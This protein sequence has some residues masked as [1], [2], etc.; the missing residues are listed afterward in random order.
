[1]ASPFH[2][3]NSL[4]AKRKE[5]SARTGTKPAAVD[6]YRA[7]LRHYFQDQKKKKRHKP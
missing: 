5:E 6:S 3:L 1:M 2:F 7:W 4:R